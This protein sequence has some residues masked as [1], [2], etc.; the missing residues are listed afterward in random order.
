MKLLP[1][2]ASRTGICV[3]I[4]AGLALPL[5][6][7]AQAPQTESNP[8]ESKTTPRIVETIHLTH[9]TA[10]RDLNDLVTDL[11]NMLPTAATYASQTQN[12]ISIRA[13]PEDMATAKKLIAEFDRPRKLFRITYTITDFDDGKRAGAHSIAVV[14]VEGEKSVAKYGNRVPIV[15]GMYEKESAGQNS[16]VQYLDVGLNIEAFFDGGRLRSKVEQSSLSEEKSGIGMQDPIVRQIMIEANS[17]MTPGKT[18]VVGS[19]DIPGTT[20]RQEIEAV[21]EPVQ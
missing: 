9:V 2:A 5:M 4:L 7:I 20:R 21:A 1:H 10:Q 8:P 18:L 13:T 19:L 12:V 16:Q 11:R 17:D 3:A 14:V 15:T 6:S